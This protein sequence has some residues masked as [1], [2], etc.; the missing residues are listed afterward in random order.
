VGPTAF[1]EPPRVTAVAELDPD[2]HP[3][4]GEA[5]VAA[6]R[7]WMAAASRFERARRFRSARR[8]PSSPEAGR[9]PARRR[10][11]G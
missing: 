7:D 8:A 10:R 2:L 1:V 3:V 11:A 6:G 9:R 5:T 4:T